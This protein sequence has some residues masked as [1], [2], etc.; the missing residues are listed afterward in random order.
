MKKTILQVVL[1]AII[2]FLVYKIYESIMQPVRFNKDRNERTVQ[3]IQ[4]LKDIRSAQVA[5]RSIHGA[6][7][8]SFDTLLEFIRT[9]EIPVV[10]MIPDPMDTTFTRSI[11]D[12]IGY[13]RVQDSLFAGRQNFD[14]R[15]FPLIPFS[16]GDT[17]TLD[18][19]QIERSKIMIDVFEASAL[20]T[21]FL[22][23]LDQ[24]LVNNYNDM[25]ESTERYPGLKVG[26]MNEATLD[27]NWE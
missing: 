13:I 2:I 3:V 9:G 7:T 24:Q 23:G 14:V 16:N 10:R 4:S 6:Y 15:S 26:S 17:F 20:N 27:G 5:Y 25:L 1:L 22:K 11:R 19:G 8:S 21:K 18:A 12:T